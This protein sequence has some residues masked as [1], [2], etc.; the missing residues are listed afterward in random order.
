[1][2]SDKYLTKLLREVVSLNAAGSCE[3]PGCNLTV[4]DPHHY[5]SRSNHAIT[6][7]S[8]SCL[9]LCSNHHVGTISAH[10]TPFIFEAMIIYY[11]VRTPEWLEEVRKKRNAI[12]PMTDD[13]RQEC[14]ER[15]LAQLKGGAA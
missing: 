1:M 5:Y 7:D 11:H 6:W 13:Y 9:W 4:C 12:Q 2:I 15:L 8:E 14:K 10:N 3:W